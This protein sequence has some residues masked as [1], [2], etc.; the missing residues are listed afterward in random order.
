MGGVGEADIFCKNSYSNGCRNENTRRGQER[1]E[2]V[3]QGTWTGVR[4][5]V[6][7]LHEAGGSLRLTTAP[8][9]LTQYETKPSTTSGN[10]SEPIGSN[11]Q[12]SES[13]MTASAGTT[14]NADT[15]TGHVS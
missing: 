11:S 4:I 12:F 15:A 8:H 9:R 3:L 7:T 1:Q 14:T 6:L 2:G 5:S 10:E 13:D